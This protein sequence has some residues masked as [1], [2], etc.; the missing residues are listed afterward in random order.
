MA[1]VSLRCSDLIRQY[2][3]T[4]DFLEWLHKLEIVAKL[5]GIN[6]LHNFVPLFLSGG[7]FAVYQGLGADTKSDYGELK[8]ALVQF[9]A[10][11]EFTSRK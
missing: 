8:S 4:G 9:S 7:A 10:F 5:Q 2:D 1:N 6:D 11:V 3:G